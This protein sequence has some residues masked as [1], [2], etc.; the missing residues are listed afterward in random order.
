MLKFILFL[1]L[2]IPSLILYSQNSLNEII[3]QADNLVGMGKS[4]E[5]IEILDSIEHNCYSTNEISIIVSFNFVKAVAL[6]SQGEYTDALS[7]FK[8]VIR[9]D[10]GN[11][12]LSAIESIGAIY[13]YNLKDKISTIKYLQKGIIRYNEI[14]QLSLFEFDNS[15]LECVA[16]ISYMLGLAYALN[17]N[18]ELAK[19]CY[20]LLAS[21]KCTNTSELMI[22][23]KRLL[24]N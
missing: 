8:E 7:N 17:G 3:Q 2:N 6:D 13:L 1:I 20:D 19:D 11:L 10:I 16:R 14:I 18:K 23:L 22:E 24:S 21:L 15:E 4:Q 12:F 5:A 9:Y